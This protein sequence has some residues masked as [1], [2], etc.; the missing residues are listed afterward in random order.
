MAKYVQEINTDQFDELIKSSKDKTILDFYSTECSPCE[1]LAPK[2]E[3]FSE[4]FHEDIKF[5]KMFRQQNRELAVDL[6]VKGSPT[7]I[8]FDGGKEVAT[9]LAGGVRKWE[10]AE[11]VKALVGE[12]RYNEVMARK[13]KQIKEADIAILGAGPGGLTAGIYAAQAKMKTVIIEENL[14]GGQVSITHSISNFPGTGGPISGMELMDKMD[15]QTRNSGAE[16][17][18][19]VD[20]SK[21]EIASDGGYHK[22]FI[23]GDDMEIRAR[24][25]VIATGSQPRP[26]NVSGEKDLKGKGISYCATC[27][28][29]YYDNQEVI[30]IGGGN[31][32]VEESIFLT[33]FA[34]KVTVVHQFDHLQANKTAQEEAFENEKINFVWNSEPRKFEKTADDRMKVVLENVKTKETTELVTDGVFIFIGYIPNTGVLDESGVEVTKDKWGYIKVNEDM[35][36]N[37]PGLFAIGDIRSKKWRQAA[38][39]VSDGCISAIVAEKY[40]ESMKRKDS[41]SKKSGAKELAG[42]AS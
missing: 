27:D 13:E 21:V 39:A 10:L 41:E 19:A 34:S 22:I 30:V 1:A 14:V 36:T 37:I 15:W 4:L 18:A 24:A 35:E 28:G 17:I 16:I 38:T 8:F 20:V 23:D 7:V 5:Y 25:L 6:G 31:S 9:R 42:V 26:L 11:Q 33:R 2:F 3:E 32:A 40:V 29:K 12:K